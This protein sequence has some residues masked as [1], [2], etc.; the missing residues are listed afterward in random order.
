MKE[1]YVKGKARIY[2]KSARPFR[3][4]A[5]TKNSLCLVGGKRRKNFVCLQHCD[6]DVVEIKIIGKL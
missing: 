6:V 3:Q 4:T 2:G 1:K 5:L